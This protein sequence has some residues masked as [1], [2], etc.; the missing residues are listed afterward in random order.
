MNGGA[1]DPGALLVLIT[2]ADPVAIRR[3]IEQRAHIEQEISE[4][5]VVIR[6]DPAALKTIAETPGVTAEDRLGSPEHIRSLG[7]TDAESLFIAGWMERRATAEKK[8]RR[9]EGLNWGTKG[10]DPP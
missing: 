2:G 1:A 4:R 9:G 6:G 3:A 5:V 7:L 10:F 8:L